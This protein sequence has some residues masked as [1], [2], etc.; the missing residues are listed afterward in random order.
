MKKKNIL[1]ALPGPLPDDETHTLGDPMRLVERELISY[2]APIG[3]DDAWVTVSFVASK[4][5][6]M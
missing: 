2:A 5:V 4:A 3:K 1:A 6:P